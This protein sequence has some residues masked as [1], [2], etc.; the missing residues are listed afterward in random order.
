MSVTTQDHC[1]CMVSDFF[2][3][4]TGGVENHI[5]YLSQHLILKGYKVIGITHCYGNRIAIRYLS[6]YFKVYYL[7]LPCVYKE[8]TLPTL[9]ATIPLIRDIVIREGVTIIHGHG[10]FSTLCAEAML[11]GSVANIPTVFTEH[12]LFHFNELSSVIT[13]KFQEFFLSDVS[14]VICVSYTR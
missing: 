9:I 6:N 12:S 14:H 11:Y 4:N 2:Y 10:G 5:Y 1:I 7:P 3:P 13:N 8:V